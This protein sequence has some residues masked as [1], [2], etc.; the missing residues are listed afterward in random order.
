MLTHGHLIT[1]HG[2]GHT[3]YGRDS[4]IDAAIHAYIINLTI[5]AKDPQCGGSAAVP[6]P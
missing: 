1:Y 6:S 4:C 3:S 5:P 2:E